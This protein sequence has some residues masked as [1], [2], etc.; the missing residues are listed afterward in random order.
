MNDK[1]LKIS[2]TTAID[3]GMIMLQ[4]G[5]E[6]YRVEETIRRMISSKTTSNVEVFVMA[7]GIIVS[8]NVGGEPYTTVSRVSSIGLDL[9]TI[10]QA[11][12][13]SRMFSQGHMSQKEVDVFLDILKSPQ[14]FSKPIRYAFSGMAGGFFVLLFGG[15][16]I[17]FFLAY[18]ASSF[19]VF[20][21]DKLTSIKLNFFVKNIVGGLVSALSSIFLVSILSLFSIA[22]DFNT[23]II[24]P[25]MTLV[26]G[27]ALTNGIRDLISGELIAGT[28]KMMEAVFIAIALA[29]G[30]GI[31][32]QGIIAFI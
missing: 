6:T 17:E 8:T 13:F 29:F 1:L 28:T 7:T 9:E 24:G 21:I 15:T 12:S 23:V 11:N 19:T 30:V 25:L 26:P 27:V 2:I 22:A 10:A 4:N 5:A 16:L 31:V 32:L 18:I 14:T 3:T 20:S